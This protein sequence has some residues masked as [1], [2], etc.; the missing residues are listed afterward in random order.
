MGFHVLGETATSIVIHTAQRHVSG[1]C[2]VDPHHFGT[3]YHMF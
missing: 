1:D 3:S 2:S